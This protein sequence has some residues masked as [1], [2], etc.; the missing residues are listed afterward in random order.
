LTIWKKSIYPRLKDLSE[1]DVLVIC[2]GVDRSVEDPAGLGKLNDEA[3]EA[4]FRDL[5]DRIAFANKKRLETGREPIRTLLV[6]EGGYSVK[7]DHIGKLLE[8]LTNILGESGLKELNLFFQY[9]EKAIT[10]QVAKF[11]GTGNDFQV[12]L[13]TSER[14]RLTRTLQ[15]A[16]GMITG[17]SSEE[18]INISNDENK[19]PS[20]PLTAILLNEKDLICP[21]GDI[22]RE[23][24]IFL[25]SCQ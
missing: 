20:S 6:L 11:S 12:V 7:D 9:R 16:D 15:T 8:K 13:D 22:F 25:N 19:L 1:F 10:E 14:I 5:T 24:E 18:A 21:G 23:I 3:F 4:F 2:L 17:T